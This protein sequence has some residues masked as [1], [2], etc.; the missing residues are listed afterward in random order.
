MNKT[1]RFTNRLLA[2][3]VC[4]LLAWV[5][6]DSQPTASPHADYPKW[7]MGGPGATGTGFTAS[8]TQG[9]PTKTE[10]SGGI[11][12]IGENGESMKGAAVRGETQDWQGEIQGAQKPKWIITVSGEVAAECKIITWWG[13]H[14]TTNYEV[15]AVAKLRFEGYTWDPDI[16]DWNSAHAHNKTAE[17]NVLIKKEQSEDDEDSKLLVNVP[18][19]DSSRWELS[20]AKVRFKIQ[21]ETSGGILFN[22]ADMGLISKAW[23]ETDVGGTAVAYDDDV[24]I[25]SWPIE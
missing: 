8:G 21:V 2:I 14:A 20:E 25:Q 3:A 1:L 16:E 15:N 17:A 24:V 11:L 12:H 6:V 9:A 23:L 19:E 18:G 7:E 10:I 22:R 4:S 13:P 5:V